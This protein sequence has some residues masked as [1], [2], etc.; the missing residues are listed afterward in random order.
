MIMPNQGHAAEPRFLSP[1]RR[2]LSQEA[3]LDPARQRH[4]GGDAESA[5]QLRGRHSLG[6][7]EQGEWVAGA[8]GDDAVTYRQVEYPPRTVNLGTYT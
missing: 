3:L 8:L 5:G 2:D 1:P 6:K 4:R 7:L